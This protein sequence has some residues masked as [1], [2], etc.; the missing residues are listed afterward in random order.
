M[1]LSRDIYERVE[2]LTNTEYNGSF[3]KEPEE[4]VLV[5]D[6]DIESMLE[7]LIL[8][9]DRLNEKIEDREKE[10]AENYERIPVSKQVNIT[11]KDFV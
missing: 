8:E 3:Y 1:K 2:Q 6:D 7:N 4:P 9:I 10:I 5:F 11:D